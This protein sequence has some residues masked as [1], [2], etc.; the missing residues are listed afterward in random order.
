MES[1]IG[2]ISLSI[3]IKNVFTFFSFLPRFY[4]FNVFKNIFSTFFKLKKT[5][6]ENPIKNFER[7]FWNHINKL[8]GHRPW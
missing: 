4:V 5:C 3:D 1:F 2:D 7:Q 8:I 6:I